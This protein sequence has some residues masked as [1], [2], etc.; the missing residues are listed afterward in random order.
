MTG[1]YT[2]I[3]VLA[4]FAAAGTPTLAQPPA[5]TDMTRLSPYVPDVKVIA[6][7]IRG[8]SQLPFHAP[9][10]GIFALCHGMFLDVGI[11]PKDLARK[12]GLSQTEVIAAAEA[13]LKSDNDTL[14]HIVKIGGMPDPRQVVEIHRKAQIAAKAYQE[15]QKKPKDGTRYVIEVTNKHGEWRELMLNEDDDTETIVRLINEAAQSPY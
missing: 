12:I 7:E 6:E 10:R 9:A 3:L 5:Y 8:L 1:N 14:C 2:R 15:C 13:R 11:G 4:L